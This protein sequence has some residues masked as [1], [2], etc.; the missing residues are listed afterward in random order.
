MA[1][2]NLDSI[3]Q[4]AALVN[5]QQAA[6][7]Q[8]VAGLSNQASNVATEAANATRTSGALQ[9]EGERTALEFELQTQKNNLALSQAFGTNVGAA[10]D[11]ITG[12]GQQM[13]QTGLDLIAKQD[14]VSKIE[15]NSDLLTNPLGWLTDLVSGD[16]VRA[17]RDALA[18]KFNTLGE[19]NKSINSATQV[20]VQTQNAIKQTVTADSINALTEAKVKAAE[21]Q[22]AQ[23]QLEG[24]K[25]QIQGV[26]ALTSVGADAYQRNIQAYNMGLQ[27]ESLAD[28]RADRALR[29]RAL[30]REE[31]KDQGELAYFNGVTERIKKGAAL[32]GRT[33]VNI[34]ANEAMRTYKAGGPRAALFQELEQVGFGLQEQGGSAT[35]ILGKTTLEAAERF[36][37]IGG[38]GEAG[39]AGESL[40]VITNA[41]Q[42]AQQ[43]LNEQIARGAKVTPEQYKKEFQTQ[44]NNQFAAG[45]RNVSQ[46]RGDYNAI[47]NLTTVIETAGKSFT[48]AGKKFADTVLS[49][50]VAAGQDNPEA[51]LVIATGIKQVQAG[52]LTQQEWKDGMHNFYQT[53][54]GLKA[55]TGGYSAFMMPMP[56]TYMISADRIRG[57]TKSFAAQLQSGL[58]NPLGLGSALQSAVGIPQP[59]VRFDLMDKASYD[60]IFT[61]MMS[62]D[63]A[64][65]IM[66]GTKK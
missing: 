53:A 55:A 27:A 6:G 28:A 41:N 29:L 52:K 38:R 24:I 42:A 21:A 66:Q 37:A 62:Q 4:A 43:V 57:D 22:S 2:F 26:N 20:G 54:L 63:R 48:P 61:V 36:A 23:M 47:P 30:Q 9:A 7:A 33:D 1:G 64:N 49:D 15:A 12:I 13:R 60:T 65:K 5:N 16:A 25:Y 56:N 32:T 46:T 17:E 59:T 31:Q 34:D 50:L 44:L 18:N 39:W 58:T 8:Q 19:V 45:A 14:E 3:L 40:K 10:S 11:V 35:G 51:E